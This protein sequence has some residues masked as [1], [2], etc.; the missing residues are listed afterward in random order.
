MSDPRTTPS[1]F[2]RGAVDLGALRPASTPAPSGP[3]AG[4]GP[5]GPGG[6]AA[7]PAPAGPGGARPR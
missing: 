2:T 6:P 4:A 1:I 7:T 3:A 5:A